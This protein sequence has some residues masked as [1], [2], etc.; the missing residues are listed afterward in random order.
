VDPALLL[1]LHPVHDGSALVDLAHLVGAA[2]VV[3]D[4]LGRGRLAGIDV[5]HDADV[6]ELG[7]LY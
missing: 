3:E 1:L 5:G 4:P 6:A 7:K 2:R